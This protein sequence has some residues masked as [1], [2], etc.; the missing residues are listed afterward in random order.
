MELNS[1]TVEGECEDFTR[2]IYKIH[3]Q[4]SNT[5]KKRKIELQTRVGDKKKSKSN[6]VKKKKHNLK[7]I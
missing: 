3:K 1:E 5:I 7:K 2:E 6:F 4:F